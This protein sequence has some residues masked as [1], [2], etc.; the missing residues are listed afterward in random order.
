MT[1]TAPNLIELALVV[2]VVVV[3]ATVGMPRR[4]ERPG[5]GLTP[6]SARVAAR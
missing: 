1:R 4:A 5:S 2:L 6:P 3:L